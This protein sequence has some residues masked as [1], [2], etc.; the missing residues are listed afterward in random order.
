[1]AEITK[2][3]RVRKDTTPEKP[4]IYSLE[5]HQIKEWLIQ[6][7]EKAFRADQVYDWLYKSVSP[8]LKI[9]PTF[10]KHYGISWNHNSPSQ[11]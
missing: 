1:M 2:S 7:G 4:S 9:C 10:R 8:V 3:S 6:N 5:L 11:H